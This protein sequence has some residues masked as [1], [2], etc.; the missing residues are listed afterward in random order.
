MRFI[1]GAL[2]CAIAAAQ[3]FEVATIKPSPGEVDTNNVGVRIDGAMVSCRFLGVRDYMRMA[4]GVKEY[5]VIGPDWL[6]STRFDI[7][8]KIPEGAQRG[9][10]PAMMEALLVERFK[11]VTHKE[12]R[13]FNVFALVVSKEGAKVTESAP[14]TDSETDTAPAGGISVSAGRGG[15]TINYGKG[16]TIRSYDHFIEA[17]RIQMPQLME[18]LADYLDK[19]AIDMSGLTGIY[20]IKLEYSLDDLRNLLRSRGIIRTLPDSL[21]ESFPVSIAESLKKLGLRLEPRK[22][23]IDVVVI[24]KIEKTPIAN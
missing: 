14:A 23:P 10:L 1:T 4:F 11:M 2:F 19:P 9:Q 3:Q 15:S 12:K 7:N 20:D 8:A 6:G 22:A 18:F 5:Q 13:E 16:S 24:D 17:K 21:A